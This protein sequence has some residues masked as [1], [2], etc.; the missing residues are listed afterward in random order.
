MQLNRVKR[1]IAKSKIYMM[2][3]FIGERK[4]I[5]ELLSTLNS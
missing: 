1:N 5:L 3:Y 2:A 4:N